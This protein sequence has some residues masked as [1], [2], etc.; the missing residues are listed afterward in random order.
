VKLKIKTVL[1]GGFLGLLLISIITILASSYISSEKVLHNHARDIMG[2]ITTLTIQQSQNYLEPAH[3]AV[4][5]TQRLAN[6]K[7]VS[8]EDKPSLERYFS[9]QLALHS[10][11]AGIYMGKPNG[12]FIYVMK[13]DSKVQG[14]LRTKLISSIKDARTTELIWRNASQK[15]LFREIDTEDTYDPRE[16]PWYKKALQ[17][18]KLIWTDPYI[19][20]SS[21][22]PGITAAS[23]V[24]LPSGKIKGIVGVDIEIDDIS[25]FLSKLKVGKNGLAFILSKNGDVIAFPDSTKIKQPLSQG[26]SKFRLTKITELDDP[27][28]RRAFESA[29]AFSNS[30]DLKEPLFSTFSENNKKYHVMFSPFTDNQWPWVIGIYL[31]ED[32]Y[33]GPIKDNRLYN[34]LIGLG[35]LTVASIIGLFIAG[36]ISKPM[37][38]LQSEAL[39][40]KGYDLDT[41]FDKKSMIRE[42]QQTSDTF[43]QMKA[44]LE[45]FKNTNEQ[46]TVDLKQ[47]ADELK[48]NEIK[49]RATFTSLIN[50]ADALIVLDTDHIIRFMNPAAESLL[51][52]KASSLKGQKFP[53]QATKGVKTEL[54]IPARN[55]SVY[56]VEMLTVDTEWEGRSA[57][58]VS[59][60][61]VSERKWAEESLS[62][63][64]QQLKNMVSRLKQREE[65]LTAIGKMAEFFQVCITEEEILKVVSESMERLFPVESGT[66]YIL[67]EENKTLSRVYSWGDNTLSENVFTL[68]T[69]WALKKGQA[70]PMLMDKSKLTC[71]HIKS[72][73]A[74]NQNFLCIPVATS[75]RQLGM[76]YLQFAS[77]AT[78]DNGEYDNNRMEQ[79]LDLGRT[80]AEHIA[81][82]LSNVRMQEKLQE[83]AIQDHLTGLYNRRYMQD[84]LEHE[85][86]RASR[87]KQPI[88]LILIDLDHFKSIND[89]HGHGAGDGVLTRIAALLMSNVRK[90]DICCRYGG[91]EF[92]II[93]PNS[94]Y[95]DTFTLAEK[96]RQQVK[97]LDINYDGHKIGNLTISA[98]VA[99]YPEQANSYDALIKAA[100]N[101]M[102]RAKDRGRDN[103]S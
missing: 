94:S 93:L 5:L 42:V 22:K 96:L 29:S 11:I 18:R 76:L 87:N 12:E 17:T 61:D 30:L 19:F 31:P 97:E 13:N 7:V 45:K 27:L 72:E 75:H 68:D 84:N 39:A 9:E 23:P 85:I 101:A 2:N 65:E 47:Q 66:F 70:Y 69:C 14:G 1:V 67:N 35:I 64:N 100:D 6:S 102:Y 91:E 40:I 57:L 46:I 62:K 92:L 48:H 80:V 86:H 36:S 24:F 28:S 78:V 37:A 56:I 41:T 99:A 4:A 60:R 33:L 51:Q 10:Q 15:E 52:E 95:K 88:G 26:S 90:G 25:I 38:A 49:L 58:L 50:F 43:A 44:G 103:V 74:S 83:M 16:R 54:T 82:A 34:I 55:N 32:D 77:S 20:F 8:S 73:G 21:Q 98:G 81:L 53:Y 79:L 3:D 59:L 63:S 89:L 71:D